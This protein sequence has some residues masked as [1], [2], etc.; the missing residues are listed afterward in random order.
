MHCNKR[1][2]CHDVSHRSHFCA[3][4]PV[5]ETQQ[6]VPYVYHPSAYL[7]QVGSGARCSA[8]FL[9]LV[10]CMTV[11]NYKC[12]TCNPWL[13][14]FFNETSSSGTRTTVIAA[15]ERL[16]MLVPQKRSL[17]PRP[18]QGMRNAVVVT[19]TTT[20]SPDYYHY[21]APGRLWLVRTQFGAW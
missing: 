13:N 18:Q 5:Y 16:W 8:S 20:T 10:F 3:R 4:G 17:A 9:L 15:R 2:P 11:Y 14:A 21:N 6:N 1:L 7:V 12:P 19:T